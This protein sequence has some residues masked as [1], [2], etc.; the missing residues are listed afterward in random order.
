[1]EQLA[2][3]VIG[4]ILDQIQ[5]NAQHALILV[6]PALIT[7]ILIASLVLTM[8]ICKAQT[9]VGNKT[10]QIIQLLHVLIKQIHVCHLIMAFTQQKSVN[11]AHQDA[12]FAIFN[13]IF[14]CHQFIQE[15]HT[16]G[17][18]LVLIMV[19]VHMP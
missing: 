6:K 18:L 8:D 9:L 17:I 14:K 13:L 2:H 5:I 4:L 19:F 12:L 11:P 3:Q 10:L 7:E 1:V 16:P 15:L